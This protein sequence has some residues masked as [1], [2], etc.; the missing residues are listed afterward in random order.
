M[1]L[2]LKEISMRRPV[3]R[4]EFFSSLS[5]KYVAII[6]SALLK[7]IFYSSCTKGSSSVNYP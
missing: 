4:E 5:S 3:R 2:H 7:C 1:L 6:T